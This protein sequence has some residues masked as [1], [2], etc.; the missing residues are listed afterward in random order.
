MSTALS[1]VFLVYVNII[2]FKPHA[3]SFSPP[4]TVFKIV[5]HCQGACLL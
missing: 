5:P 1:C 3:V 4:G 2:M